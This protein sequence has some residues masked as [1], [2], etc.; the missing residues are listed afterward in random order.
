M[1]FKPGISKRYPQFEDIQPDTKVIKREV[2]DFAVARDCYFDYDDAMNGYYIFHKL[3]KLSKLFFN[4]VIFNF[5]VLY[6][7]VINTLHLL[8]IFYFLLYVPFKFFYL[9]FFFNFSFLILK[10]TFILFYFIPVFIF[11]TLSLVLYFIYKFYKLK[12]KFFT[13]Q[14]TSL[15]F[16]L[17]SGFF[18]SFKFVQERFLLGLYYI[19][20]KF[21][22]INYLIP[23]SSKKLA[24]L[25]DL[26]N[27]SSIFKLSN[28]F[29][30]NPNQA[31]LLYYNTSYVF[32]RVRPYLLRFNNIQFVPFFFKT[33]KTSRVTPDQLAAFFKIGKNSRYPV[34]Y[35]DRLFDL[36]Y[37]KLELEYEVPYYWSFVRQAHSFNEG[38][39]H[40]KFHVY[41][42]LNFIKFYWNYFS[43]LNTNSSFE[44][45]A[46]YAQDFVQLLNSSA[47]Q[48]FSL[49]VNDFVLLLGLKK[50]K[51]YLSFS[52]QFD[53]S[54]YFKISNIV[55]STQWYLFH[56]KY[57]D[58]LI[59]F[60]W[61]YYDKL[62]LRVLY[63]YYFVG[64]SSK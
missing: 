58:D 36:E 43:F 22:S 56:V 1:I 5:V 39:L 33:Q 16:F 60:I 47:S 54:V 21:R 15:T 64:S 53:S 48:I 37:S 50:F 59:R 7:V 62:F 44:F 40:P 35:F 26:F 13:L 10:F 45:S 63:Y 51:K 2:W 20:F 8:Q 28:I 24:S 4:F 38:L 9:S 3:R 49:L 57:Y 11:L 41:G 34:D 31:N 30:I 19:I 55:N 14:K 6:F 52:N 25:R 17:N 18:L 29:K 46:I 12:F 61:D 27:I 23:L 42:L 32:K